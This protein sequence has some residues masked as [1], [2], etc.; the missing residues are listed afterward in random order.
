MQPPS[1]LP[2]EVWLREARR[3]LYRDSTEE[4]VEGR[5]ACDPPP[6]IYTLSPF[7]FA[8]SL[9]PFRVYWGSAATAADRL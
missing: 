4:F 5:G 8:Y 7:F 1:L 2:V 6:A 3:A 9:S